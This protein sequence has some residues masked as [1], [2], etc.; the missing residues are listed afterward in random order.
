MKRTA[1]FILLALAAAHAQKPWTVEDIFKDGGP[2]GTPPRSIEWSPD[3]KLLTFLAPDDTV[4]SS[5]PGKP[6]DLLAL[7]T[8]TGKISVLATQDKLASATPLSEKDKDHRA[9]Y[10][11]PSYTWAADSKHLIL[12][13]GG[14]ISLYDVA[15]QTATRIVDTQNGSGDDPRFSPDARS[16]SYLRD[17]NLYVAPATPDSHNERNLTNTAGDTLL[18]GEVDWV[19]LEELDVRSNYFWSPDSQRIA[20]LQADETKVPEYPLPDLS[21][22]HAT[23]DMQRYPQPGDPNPSVRVGVVSA[24]GSKTK[25]LDIPQSAGNDYIP[26]FGWVDAQTLYVEVLTRDQKHL[27]LYLADAT[28]GKSHLIFD[29]YDSKYLDT[30]YDVTFIDDSRFILKSWHSGH[31]HL[32]LYTIDARHPLDTTATLTQQLTTGGYEVDELLSVD[33]KTS[34]VF[35]TSNE[36]NPLENALWT[37][38]LDGTGKKELT[39]SPGT[40]Y[41]ELAPDNRNFI[42]MAGSTLSPYTVSL[43]DLAQSCTTIWRPK[44]LTDLGYTPIA[45]R[46]L[47]LKAADKITTLYASL[48][49]PPNAGEKIPLILNPYGGPH[50]QSVTNS[51]GG[52]DA[53][54]DQLLSQH[55]FAVLHVDNRGMG[56]R[57][58]DFEQAAFNNFGPVQLEDQLTAL[59]QIL[60]LYPQLDPARIG[61]WGWSWGGTFT[62]YAMEHSA[63][64]GEPARFKAGVA[65]APVTDWQ[66][67]DSIYT[68]RYLGLPADNAKVYDAG[69]TLKAAAQLHGKLLL[70]HGTGDDNVHLSNSMQQQQAFIN[71]QIPFDLELFPGKTHSI[72]GYTDRVNLFN[73]ILQYFETNLK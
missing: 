25:W 69:S 36:G 54:F 12:D 15:S 45:P 51:W 28:S 6:G 70:I 11:M 23:V 50:E 44:T 16:I 67:Y 61:F 39:A 46:Q 2:T 40:H 52:G 57:G 29:G 65:V 3:G 22:T 9:R 17:H 68:E 7:D 49:L 4:G 34:T 33:P 60:K 30:N 37:I 20:Y 35:Y 72:A 5:L 24:K 66:L 13:A 14:V 71:A 63:A 62:L 21:G 56:E 64:A 19:Y 31:T 55:G 73:H 8:A 32:Y 27:S 47:Q 42:D 1:L 53:L 41:I 58:R 43:C 26:R 48:I 38:Q 59:D 18:N 10:G